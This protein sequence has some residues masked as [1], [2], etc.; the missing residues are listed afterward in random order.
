MMA[1][2]ACLISYL[3]KGPVG[4]TRFGWTEPVRRAAET[5]LA[6]A[7]YCLNNDDAPASAVERAV[8]PMRARTGAF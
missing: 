5:G 8:I 7:F 3:L 2:S 1:F 4:G 6:K